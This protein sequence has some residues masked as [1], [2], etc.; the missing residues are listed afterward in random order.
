VTKRAP[1]VVVMKINE[2]QHVSSVCVGRSV[3]H[4]L[5][6]REYYFSELEEFELIHM[7]L[8]ARVILVF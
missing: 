7:L 2:H 3:G 4:Y 5:H 6:W 1:F 8:E